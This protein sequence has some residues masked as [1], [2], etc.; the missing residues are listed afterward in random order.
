VAGFE[1]GT[2]RTGSDLAQEPE[3]V[4]LATPL[5]AFTREVERLPGALAGR[6]DLHC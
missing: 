5:A 2:V 4:G 3:D 6:V 1:I